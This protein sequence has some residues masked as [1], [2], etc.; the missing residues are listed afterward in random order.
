LISY[1]ALPQ[2][3]T[4][5][6]CFD[7]RTAKGYWTLRSLCKLASGNRNHGTRAHRRTWP[8]QLTLLCIKPLLDAIASAWTLLRDAGVAAPIASDIV[9]YLLIGGA[10]TPYIN[11]PEVRLLTG[12]DPQS[13]KWMSAHADA[14]T[15]DCD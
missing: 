9:Y 13:S 3:S 7:P 6:S 12:H 2:A 1:R 11:A 15:Q 8:K 5:R 4:T 10:S 14:L